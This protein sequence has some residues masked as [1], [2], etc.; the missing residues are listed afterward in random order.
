MEQWWKHLKGKHKR[1]NIK[2]TIHCVTKIS[3][4]KQLKT[5]ASKTNRKTTVGGN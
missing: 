4:S 2:A 1:V 5:I 3:R